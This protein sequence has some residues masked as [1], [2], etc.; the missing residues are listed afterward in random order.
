MRIF[1]R[2]YKE[3]QEKIYEL[4]RKNEQLDEMN[5]D[6]KKHIE[7]FTERECEIMKSFINDGSGV[8]KINGKLVYLKLESINRVHDLQGLE[9]KSVTMSGIF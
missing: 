3:M 8:A 1:F 4:Q 5:E 9:K 2:K 7:C 6:L